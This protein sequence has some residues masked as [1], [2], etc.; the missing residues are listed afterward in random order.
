METYIG[1]RYVP[2]IEGVWDKSKPY[3]N[4]S[5]VTTNHTSYTSTQNV[6]EGVDISNT[7]FWVKTGDY[8]GQVDE[9]KEEVT[10]QLAQK[11]QQKNRY[12]DD[13]NNKPYRGISFHFI[14]GFTSGELTRFKGLVKTFYD[15]GFNSIGLYID[16]FVSN[17]EIDVRIGYVNELMTEIR[18]YDFQHVMFRCCGNFGS[19]TDKQLYF[20][21]MSRCVLRYINGTSSHTFDSVAIGTEDINATSAYKTEWLSVITAIRGVYDGSIV[22]VS[23][24]NQLETLSFADYVDYLGFDVYPALTYNP[25]ITKISNQELEE[26]FWVR[27]GLERIYNYCVKHN[28][29]AFIIESGNTPFRLSYTG[30]GT[31]QTGLEYGVDGDSQMQYWKTALSIFDNSTWLKGYMMFDGTSGY[32]PISKDSPP[33]LKQYIED[34]FNGGVENGK[35]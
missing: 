29:K 16:G 24:I 34:F 13:K 27:G 7:K 33:E 4:L 10:A 31:W 2:K 15:M 12:N 32:S 21:D 14:N 22:S 3:E 5:I 30:P 20:S 8:I 6:P 19:Y 1:S 26:K 35:I 28:K 18:K 9:F 23:Y 25:E 17:S 11:V